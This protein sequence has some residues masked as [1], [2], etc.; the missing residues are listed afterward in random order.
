MDL[1]LLGGGG[2]FRIRERVKGSIA[3]GVTGEILTI[4]APIGHVARLT[5]LATRSSFT[6]SGISV[7]NDGQEIVTGTLLNFQTSNTGTNGF[8]IATATLLGHSAEPETARSRISEIIGEHIVVN[9]SAGDTATN[10][11]YEVEYGVIE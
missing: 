7:V 5:M 3:S 10:I 2:M 9:K 11:Y 8:C 1:S 4:N 6:Q